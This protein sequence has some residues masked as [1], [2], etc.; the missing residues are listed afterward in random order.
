MKM[1]GTE[2]STTTGHQYLPGT[3]RRSEGCDTESDSAV[4]AL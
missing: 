1:R 2:V 3:V 4:T